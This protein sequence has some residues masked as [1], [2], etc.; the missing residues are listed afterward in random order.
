MTPNSKL[1]LDTLEI[2]LSCEADFAQRFYE[3]LFKANPELEPLFYRSSRGALA[4][5][6]A[7][8]LVAIVDHLDDP[9]W[10]ERELGALAHAH[11]GYG[12]SADMYPPVGAALIATLKEACG[13]DWTP[14]AEEA[15][16]AAYQRLAAAMTGP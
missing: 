2:A 8:K 10:V 16:A 1:L 9:V 14:E 12:V 3:L 13:S 7:Q 5:M 11:H 6:F 4:K 15:W